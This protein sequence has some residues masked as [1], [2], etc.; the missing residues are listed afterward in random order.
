MVDYASRKLMSHERN[1]PMHD[2]KL[3]AIVFTLKI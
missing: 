2:L 3:A 1:Y